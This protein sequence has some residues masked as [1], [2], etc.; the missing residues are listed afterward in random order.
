MVSIVVRY[1]GERFQPYVGV[2]AGWSSSFLV[3][4]QITKGGITESGTARDTSFASQYFAGLRT[5]LTKRVFL[6]TEYRY[7][8]SRYD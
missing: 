8:A 4:S 1:P 7:F 3:D 6:F 5:N 2:G